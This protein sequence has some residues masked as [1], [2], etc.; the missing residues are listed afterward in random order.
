MDP[1]GGQFQVRRHEVFV[2]LAVTQK[3]VCIFGEAIDFC[4]CLAAKRF[5]Q[6]FQKD[7]ITLQGHHRARSK[8]PFDIGNATADQHVGQDDD[9][10][11]DVTLKP[12][13]EPLNLFS[14]KSA[15]AF[16]H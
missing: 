4:E 8:L 6:A 12:R 13:A 2:E 15:T 3:C 9:I 7:I 11:I 5:W 1:F 16:Q 10:G 14:L